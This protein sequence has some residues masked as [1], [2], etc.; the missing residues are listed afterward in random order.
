MRKTVP[1][2]CFCL[3]LTAS[4][5]YAAVTDPIPI[6][7]SLS[8][9]KSK[10]LFYLL[11]K[12]FCNDPDRTAVETLLLEALGEGF[13]GMV[14]VGEVIRNRQKLFSAD[15]AKVCRMPKQ[16]SCWNNE[17]RAE[18]FLKKHR[19]YYFVALLAWKHSGSTSLTGGAT[20]YHADSI[21][22]YWAGAYR[23][24]AR[25]RNHI[26]YVRQTGAKMGG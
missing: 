6:Q 19:F 26:F 7:R 13:Y 5:I 10:P 22:P 3:T 17:E 12:K 24:S 18:E 8:I 21:L 9:E 4:P 23:V 25:I 11:T 16:F 2:L 1:I 15:A 14:A 20:D